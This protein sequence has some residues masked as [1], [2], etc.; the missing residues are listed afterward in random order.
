M[1]HLTH[2]FS[3]VRIHKISAL[4]ASRAVLA[5]DIAEKYLE[6]GISKKISGAASIV[7]VSSVLPALL[8]FG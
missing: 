6:E 8:K 5:G 2:R 3:L 7:V 1:Y 4:L